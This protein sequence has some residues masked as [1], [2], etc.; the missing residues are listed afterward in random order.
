MI[1]AMANKIANAT[2]IFIAR[3]FALSLV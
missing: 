1:Q 2:F 3:I